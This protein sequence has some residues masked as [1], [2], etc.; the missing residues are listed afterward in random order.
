[1]SSINT[2]FQ[3][4]SDLQESLL[5]TDN[6]NRS[7]LEKQLIRY[8]LNEQ[9][10]IKDLKIYKEFEIQKGLIDLL[11][12]HKTIEKKT[13]FFDVHIIELK[14][15]GI[16]YRALDQ[17]LR[18]REYVQ[19]YFAGWDFTE[20]LIDKK[21]LRIF[22][23]LVGTECDWTSDSFYTMMHLQ[24]NYNIYNHEYYLDPVNGLTF[25]SYSNCQQ[26]E[27]EVKECAMD[28][29][30]DMCINQFKPDDN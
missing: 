10:I 20:M 19:N 27:I 3:W 8:P 21:R 25:T 13:E 2:Y 18:Y 28:E 5:M 6:E 29:I 22:S 24:K 7:I 1:M 14:R 23:H 15:D 11:A 4:E 16:T 17:I 30:V 26:T 12:V 9:A